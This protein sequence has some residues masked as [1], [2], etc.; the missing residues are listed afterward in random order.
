MGAL[1]L[2]SMMAVPLA[3]A[4]YAPSRV[5]TS[6]P[7][8]SGAS[9]FRSVLDPQLEFGPTDM[10]PVRICSR[11]VSRPCAYIKHGINRIPGLSARNRI[12]PVKHMNVDDDAR[13]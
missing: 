2:L 5:A 12:E 8:S 6:R 11:V 10:Q 1:L 4:Q 13:Q 3:E 7:V 9:V